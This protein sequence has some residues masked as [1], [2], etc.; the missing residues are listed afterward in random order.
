MA[1]NSE[2]AFQ[3]RVAQDFQAPRVKGTDAGMV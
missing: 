3:R 2:T 1:N